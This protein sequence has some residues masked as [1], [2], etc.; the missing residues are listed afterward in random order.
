MKQAFTFWEIIIALGI[1]LILFIVSFQGLGSFYYNFLLSNE[2]FFILDI[3][4]QARLEALANYQSLPRGVYFTTSEYIL[5]SGDNFNNRD[6]RYDTSFPRSKIIEI[7]SPEQ[8]VFNNFSAT[9][10]VSTTIVLKLA[11]NQRKIFINNE[12]L[13]DWQ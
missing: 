10:S 12:A 13:L 6:A 11:N 4:N 2:E 8:I 1:F 7:I 5:F 9:T 3:L